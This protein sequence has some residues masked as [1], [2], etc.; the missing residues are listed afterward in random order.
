MIILVIPQYG[1]LV[2]PLT[3]IIK[4][5]HKQQYL[6]NKIKCMKP[7]EYNI[8]LVLALFKGKLLNNQR[9]NYGL[10][11]TKSIVSMA[12]ATRIS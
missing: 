12:L 10:M 2:S 5:F 1:R 3:F 6:F 4:F 7:L 8:P 9:I 11:I